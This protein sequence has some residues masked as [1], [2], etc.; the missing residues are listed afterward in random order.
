MTFDTG[1]VRST[2]F[3]KMLET[4]VKE[5]GNSQG[6]M[7]S[8]LSPVVFH[9]PIDITGKC[10]LFTPSTDKIIQH[11]FYSMMNRVQGRLQ[12]WEFF[13]ATPHPVRA[14]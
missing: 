6:W 14:H 1:F 9:S 8:N 12:R 5:S 13:E 2:P 10:F 11:H 7:K 4:R 3:W